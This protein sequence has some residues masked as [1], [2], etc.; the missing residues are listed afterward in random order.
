MNAVEIA[1]ELKE[2]QEHRLISEGELHSHVNKY[3]FGLLIANLTVVGF[4]LQND[5]TM[6]ILDKGSVKYLL[7]ASL[8]L[9]FISL[10]LDFTTRVLNAKYA[11]N[12]H[13]SWISTLRSRSDEFTIT[14]D[15]TDLPEDSAS[16][17]KA[18]K[19]KRSAYKANILSVKVG[20]YSVLSLGLSVV[21]SIMF[22]TIILSNLA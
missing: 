20:K 9:S 18:K 8:Y 12:I 22:V 15:G 19:Y 13:Y 2:A 7:L 3:A 17:E 16:A 6:R 1:E 14:V 11:K 21:C 5:F 10:T 4:L